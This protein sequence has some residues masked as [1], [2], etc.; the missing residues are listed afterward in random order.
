[1]SH[2]R[3]LV[4]DVLIDEQF[5]LVS[6]LGKGGMGT[7]WSADDLTLARPVAIKFLSHE[8]LNDE[9][10]RMRF[11]REPRLASKIRSPHVVQVFAQGTTEDDVPY[12]VMELLEGADLANRISHAGPFGLAEAGVIVEQVCRALGRAHREGLVHRDIKPHNIFLTPESDGQVFVKLLDFGIAKDAGSRITALT[13]TGEV[14]G[15]ALYVSPEQLHE[16]NSV[17]PSTDIWSLGIVI[18]E[19]LT[20]RLPFEGRSLPELF[21]RVTEGNYRPVSEIEPGLPQALDAFFERIIKVDPSLRFQ[22]VD[23]LAAAFG[24]IVRASSSGLLMKQDTPREL[25]ASEYMAVDSLPISISPSTNFSAAPESF[26]RTTERLP[27]PWSRTVLAAVVLVSI[28]AAAYALRV[29]RVERAAAPP[30]SAIPQPAAS[31]VLPPPAAASSSQR[32]AAEP[33]A[34]IPSP[35]PTPP[36]AATLST[37]AAATQPSAAVDLPRGKSGTASDAVSNPKPKPK[38]PLAATP[39]SSP[40][41]SPPFKPMPHN[42][43]F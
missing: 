18:Y 36:A 39:R 25:L 33:A 35:A 28:I 30:A 5:R 37:P 11:A 7:V 41:S 17:G 19:M 4:R 31:A 20:G 38:P 43:G 9:Q 14:V 24:R 12:L 16:A 3:K 34:L 10:A 40:T 2:S 15:S 29:K 8:F 26:A 22:S 27:R 42:H 13:L 21:M 23:E 32:L 6:Q 1:M